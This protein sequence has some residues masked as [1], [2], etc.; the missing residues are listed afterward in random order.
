[1]EKDKIKQINKQKTQLFGGF[2]VNGPNLY[3]VLN[4]PIGSKK[5]FI[6]Y[7]TLHT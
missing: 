7:I 2:M 6:Q 5:D 1:M 3:S 4:L